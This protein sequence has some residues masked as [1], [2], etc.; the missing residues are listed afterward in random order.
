MMWLD[1]PE[2]WKILNVEMFQDFYKRIQEINQFSLIMNKLI[3]TTF[4]K[5]I[6]N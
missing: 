6:V 5:I 1:Y 4:D 3:F 2:Y